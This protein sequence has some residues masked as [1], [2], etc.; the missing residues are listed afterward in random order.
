MGIRIAEQPAEEPIT[1]AEAKEWARVTISDDDTLIEA[2]IKA[3]REYAEAYTGRAF[4]QRQMLLTLDAFPDNGVILLPFPPLLSVDSVKYIDYQGVLQT[5]DAADYQV[6]T[7]SEP[8]RI[9]PAHLES[10]DGTR[11]DFNAVQVLYQAGYAV[12]SPADYRQNLPGLLRQW[13]KARISTL[14]DNRDQLITGTIVAPLPHH[15]ADGLLDPL[16]VATRLFG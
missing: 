14:Y 11:N 4:V 9:A 10:W 1:V 12:G 7:E 15:F 5:V 16:I 6:D 13:M 2:L 8:G 3:M